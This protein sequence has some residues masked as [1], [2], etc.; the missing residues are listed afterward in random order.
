MDFSF[1][2]KADFTCATITNYLRAV[3]MG[4]YFSYAKALYASEKRRS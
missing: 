2:M 3:I 1:Q 4:R